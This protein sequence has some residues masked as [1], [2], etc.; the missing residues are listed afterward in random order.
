[1]NYPAMEIKIIIDYLF[2]NNAK[3]KGF[4]NDL[5]SKPLF[6]ILGHKKGYDFSIF[7][8][9]AYIAWLRV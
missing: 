8:T 2:Y 3:E 7:A 4:K 5:Y 6:L 9:A 1:M